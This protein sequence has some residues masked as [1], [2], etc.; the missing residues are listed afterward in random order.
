MVEVNRTGLFVGLVALVL[1]VRN[2]FFSHLVLSRYPLYPYRM[3]GNFVRCSNAY[4]AA[5]CKKPLHRMLFFNILR[6]MIPEILKELIFKGKLV[7][8]E[9]K[10]VFSCCITYTLI[11]HFVP[12]R[13]WRRFRFFWCWIMLEYYTKHSADWIDNRNQLE[14]L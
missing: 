5:K 2:A 10:F 12:L 9:I 7:I 13:I 3:T 8:P 6:C 4:F 1:F 14:L 11:F